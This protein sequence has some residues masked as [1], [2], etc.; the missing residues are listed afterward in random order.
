[1]YVYP[2]LRLRER[3]NQRQEGVEKE[4]PFFS[5][6]VNVLCSAG[7]PLYS[8]FEG[9]TGTKIFASMK[10]EALLVRRDVR[11]FGADP[12]STFERI[13]SDHPSKRF[14]L[15]LN[16]YTSK[17]RSGGDIPAYLTGESGQLLREL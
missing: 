16:G 17:V 12:N 8:I 5:I 15:F 4:L 3:A 14:S 9:I 2:E 1:V 6:M 13:A 7:M 10:R 11:V